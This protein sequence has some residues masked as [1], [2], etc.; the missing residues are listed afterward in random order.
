MVVVPNVDKPESCSE[1]PAHRFCLLEY[2]ECGF[3]KQ[4]FNENKLDIVPYDT[5]LPQC[6]ILQIDDDEIEYL[7]NE[8]AK[9]SDDNLTHGAQ[10]LKRAILVGYVYAKTEDSRCRSHVNV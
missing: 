7:F 8:F 5:V 2:D 1:C 10:E 3:L 6:P 9:E 4:R